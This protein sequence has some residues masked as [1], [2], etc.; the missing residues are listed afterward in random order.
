MA[1]IFSDYYIKKFWESSEY[2]DGSYVGAQFTKKQVASIEDKLAYKLPASYVDLMR[3]Q[4]GGIPKRTKYRIEGRTLSIRGIFSIGHENPYSLC[5]GFGSQ[6]WIKEWKYPAIGIYFADCP[7][8]GHD[9]FCLD[10]QECGVNGEPR[11]V[12]VDQGRN[13]E[14]TFIA[15]NFKAFI[16]GLESEEDIEEEG[17]ERG[18]NIH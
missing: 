2:A 8:A 14:I 17:R 11:V 12:H 9:M 4:N 1:K 6:F 18:N 3:Y 7:Y 16:L 15:D 13:Y 5:G 10:Y